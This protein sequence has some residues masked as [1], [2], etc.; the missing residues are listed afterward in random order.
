MSVFNK[1]YSGFYDS[2]YAEKDYKGE[3]DFLEKVFRKY[4]V[5]PKTILDLGCGTGAHDVILAQRGYKVTGV[6]R[7]AHMLGLARKKAANLGLNIDYKQGDISRLKLKGK[8]DA[9]ISMFAVMGY[10]TSNAAFSAACKLAR[11]SLKPG[12]VFVFDCWNGFAVLQDRPVAKT[13]KIKTETGTILRRTIPELDFWHHL[14]NVNFE[15]GRLVG[16]KLRE[17][18]K[19]S[20]PMRFL[21]PQEIAQFMQAAGFK[22]VDLYP[23][24]SLTK[25]LTEAD[26]NMAVVGRVE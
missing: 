26:W 6:D 3:C 25:S 17:V 1:T 5:A 10:Q 12:G 15:T 8:Y 16:G 2:L 24:Y 19:E 18:V 22:K 13:K 7:S 20:H 21:F 11:Q 23:C 9:V 4:K 14:V